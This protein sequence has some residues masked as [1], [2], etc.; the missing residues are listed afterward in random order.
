MRWR[1]KVV[2]HI[3]RT[4]IKRQNHVKRLS[5]KVGYI[6]IYV[7]TSVKRKIQS[8]ASVYP[9]MNADNF[10]QMNIHLTYIKKRIIRRK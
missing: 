4:K 1:L 2:L 5:K 10:L 9:V 6:V 8:T 3:F 7:N